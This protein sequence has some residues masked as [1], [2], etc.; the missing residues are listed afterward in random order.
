MKKALVLTVLSAALLVSF[1][2]SAADPV[3]PAAEAVAKSPK[4]AKKPQSD[5]L[6]ALTALGTELKAAIGAGKG[7]P[8]PYLDKLA[9]H[10]YSDATKQKLT[11]VFG[12]TEPLTIKRSEADGGAVAYAVTAPAHTYRDQDATT[13]SWSELGVNLLVDKAGQNMTSS[14]NWSAFSVAGKNVTM[15]A[16]DMTLES[17]QRRSTQNIWLGT[18]KAGIGKVAITP[19]AGPGV[20]MEDM[21]FASNV[22]QHGKMIDIGYESQIKAIKVVGESV[23]DFRFAMRMLNID[24]RT[25]EKMTD[26]ITEA[27]QAGKT[28]DQQLAVIMDQFKLLGK[29]AALRGTSVEIDDFSLGFHGN[30]AVIKGIVS[31]LKGSD[32]DFV[33][34]AKFANK[35]V[36]RLQ[37][38]VPLALV[39]DIAKAVMTKE[40]QGKGE[41]PSVD[42]IAQAAQSVTDVIVGKVITGGFAKL[43][44]GV[45]VSLIE[46]KGGKLTFNGKEVALPKGAAKP[47][48]KPVE[49]AKPEAN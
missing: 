17:K 7:N 20:V 45:L 24:M 6:D 21:T 32:A 28:K 44:D 15:T 38:R 34:T 4:A 48:A 18:V 3:Q 11:K 33:T 9:A 31:L 13:F 49:T 27:E 41:K 29:S 14:G 2:A 1:P 35:V 40:A 36:A 5:M 8:I 43:E 16:S 37:V 19:V 47:P 23:D 10:E 46:F 12:N 42:G 30:R 39:N 26:A 25:L 22:T